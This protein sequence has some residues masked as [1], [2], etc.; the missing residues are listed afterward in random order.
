[1]TKQYSFVSEAISRETLG[2]IGKAATILGTAGMITHSITG[3]KAR[4]KAILKKF[5]TPK[6]MAEFAKQ[7]GQLTK[8]V[9]LANMTQHEYESLI[10]DKS[11]VRWFKSIFANSGLGMLFGLNAPVY[12]AKMINA[13]RPTAAAKRVIDKMN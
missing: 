5:P 11:K 10:N 9:A 2:K 1:M 6:D 7:Q 12:A 4:V 13:R 8:A 3:K